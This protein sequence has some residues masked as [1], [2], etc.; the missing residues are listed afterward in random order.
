MLKESFNSLIN[1]ILNEQYVYN[2][3]REYISFYFEVKNLNDVLNK[4][5]YVYIC[6]NKY[7]YY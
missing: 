6:I 7:M 1:M 2:T 3:I 5:V 4:S